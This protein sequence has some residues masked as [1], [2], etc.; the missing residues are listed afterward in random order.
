MDR[1]ERLIGRVSDLDEVGSGLRFELVAGTETLPAF[2][3]RYHGGGYAYANRCA[4]LGVEL[5]WL[6]GQFFD[7]AQGHLVCS[8]HGALFRPN[9]GYCIEGP[10]RGASLEPLQVSVRG[11]NIF[12]SI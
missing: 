8:T 6:P 1:L 11:G 10:C 2:A 4:H 12:V 3:V 9:D 5:D 7:T